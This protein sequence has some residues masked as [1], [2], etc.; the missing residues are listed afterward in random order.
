VKIQ[1]VEGDLLDQRVEA[2]VNAWNRNTIPW[3][4]LLPQG[5][6]GAIKRRGGTEPF[7]ELRRH[8]RMA[9]G[10]A[11]VTRA[12]RLPYRG[13]VHVAGI[14]D[15]WHGSERATRLSVR[16]A[17]RAAERSGFESL[18][19]PLVGSGSWGLSPA[20][21]ERAILD[22]LGKIESDITVTVVRYRP[23]T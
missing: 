17:V 8:G 6:S 23:K 10:E 18:A 22:E 20:Q 2:I 5:V 13:I 4:L 9:L 21:S 15:L 16:N 14:D 19:I 1:V 12:G 3:W 11:I 7:K